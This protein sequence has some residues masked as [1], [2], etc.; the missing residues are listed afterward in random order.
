MKNVCYCD[1][2]I[3]NKIWPIVSSKCYF[4][5]PIVFRHNLGQKQ[6]FKKSMKSTFT[7]KCSKPLSR[8]SRVD[9][10]L[11]QAFGHATNI[12]FIYNRLHD[13]FYHG[14]HTKS[15]KEPVWKI[16]LNEY[17]NLACRVA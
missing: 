7:R 4:F 10:M 15:P 16:L 1:L 14:Y 3:D 2:L 8:A 6:A 11:S 17:L 13:K 5:K 9:S 12:F